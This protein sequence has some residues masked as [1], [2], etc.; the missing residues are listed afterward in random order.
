MQLPQ[1]SAVVK[2]Q[3]W[4][5]VKEAPGLSLCYM[6]VLTA[7]SQAGALGVLCWLQ[8]DRHLQPQP[9]HQ[10]RTRAAVH[11]VGARLA[12]TPQVL[13]CVENQRAS[14]CKQ[15]SGSPG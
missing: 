7:V 3:L 12:G 10:V 14:R 6:H 4:K 1:S 9:R 2:A 11:A 13:V 8:E 5:K 15:Q